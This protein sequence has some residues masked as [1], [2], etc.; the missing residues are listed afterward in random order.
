MNKSA[1]IRDIFKLN[2]NASQSEI[3][4]QFNVSRQL[5]NVLWH[6]MHGKVER[7]LA[8]AINL[9]AIGVDVNTIVSATNVTKK[10]ARLYINL[11]KQ[12]WISKRNQ[13]I[14]ELREKGLPASKI[15]YMLEPIMSEGAVLEIINKLGGKRLRRHRTT[16]DKLTFLRQQAAFLK[17]EMNMKYSQIATELSVPKTSVENL[18][19]FRG[20]RR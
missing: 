10:T 13:R 19:W 16:G 4:K 18:L 2:K 8:G 17:D 12:D 7:D 5:V 14:L 3:A 6:Q 11:A 15:R 1:A 20:K 9:A